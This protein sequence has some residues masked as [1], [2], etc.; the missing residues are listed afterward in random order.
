[1]RTGTSILSAACAGIL[2]LSAAFF[3][4]PAAAEKNLLVTEGADYF[5]ADYDVVKDVGLAACKSACL[6]DDRCKAFT[7]NTSAGWC[8]LKEGVGE[9]RAVGSA[10]SGRVVES[11]VNARSLAEMRTAELSFLPAGFLDEARRLVGSLKEGPSGFSLDQT[12]AEAENAAAGGNYLLATERMKAGLRIAPDRPD[13][14]LRLAAFAA[15]ANSDDWQ[16]RQR[17]EEERTAAA[18]NAY[19]NADAPR[20][21]AAALALLARSLGARDQWKPAIKAYRGSLALEELPDVRAAYEQALAQHG[22]RIVDHQVDSDAANPRICLNFSDALPAIR[23]DLADFIFVEN[24]DNLSVEASGSQICISGVAHG[25]RYHIRAR[26]G[27]PSADGEELQKTAE[28]GIYVRDRSPSARFSGNAYVV[29]AGGSA[30]LPVTTVNTDQIEAELY[31]IPDRGIAGTMR[32]DLFLSQ[33]RDWQAEE[34][35]NAKGEKIWKGAV[36]VENTLN[37]EVVT[38]IPIGE[39]VSTLQPGIYVLRASAR[40]EQESWTPEAT[41]WFLASDLGIATLSGN[42]GLHAS[43]RALGTAAPVEGAKLRLVAKNNEVLAEAAT[44]ASGQASFAP[45]LVRG[46]GG[47]APAILVAE[48]DAGD[49]NFLDL[50]KPAFDLTDRGVEG[51]AA[52]GPVDVFATTERGIYRAGETVYLTTLARNGRSEAIANLPLTAKLFRPDGKEDRSILLEDEGLGGALAEIDLSANAMRGQ[53]RA[54]IYTDPKG[55]SV[56]ETSFF[57]EDFEPERLDFEL[58][59]AAQA[60]DPASPPEITAEARFLYGAPASGLDAE[61]EAIVSASD[62]IEAFPGYRFGLADEEFQTLREPQ[63]GLVTDGEGR[64]DF[65]PTLPDGMV[66]SRP[67][68]AAI[69]IRVVD[70][71]GR[72]VERSLKLPVEGNAPRIGIRPAFQGEVDDNSDAA[73][74]VIAISPEGERIAAEDL[75]WTLSKVDRDYQW[76]RSNGEWNYEVLETRRHVSDGTARVGVEAPAAI[77]APVEWGKYEIE[78][79]SKSGDLLPASFTFEAGWYAAPKTLETPEFL[80]LSLDKERYRIGETAV[81]HLE[82]RFAGIAQVMVIDDRLI[83]TK[84]VEVSEGSAEIELPVTEDWGPGAYVTAALYRPMD[85]A[86]KRMPARAL[87]LSWASVENEAQRLNVSLEA[88]SE[89]KPR[90][91][92][93][94]SISI[95][96]L[97]EGDE[98]YVTLAAVDLGILNLTGFET[99]DPEAFYLGQRRLGMEI[100]DVYSALIDRFAGAPGRVR[101]GGDAALARFEGPAPTEEL[102]AWHSSVVR[103]GPDG[104]ASFDVPVGDFNG[105]VRLMALAWSEKGVGHGEKDVL[106]R[107]PV[108]VSAALPRFMAPGDTSRIALDI[109]HAEGPAGEVSVTVTSSDENV[110]RPASAPLTT[111]LAEGGRE[112]L[113]VP[114]D[115]I[116]EGDATLS[117]AL[118]TPAGEVLEKSL[119]LTVRDGEPEILRTS[120][121]SLAPGSS[122]DLDGSILDGLKPGSAG[123]RVSAYGAGRLDVPAILRKLDRYPYGCAEQLTSRALPLVY[124]NEVSDALGMARDKAA[125][126]RIEKAIEGVLAYQSSSGSFGLWR[127]GSDDL[128]LDSYVTD[129]LSRARRAGYT[130]PE[131]AFSIALDNLKNRIAYAPDFSDAGEDIAYALYVLAENGRAAIGDLRYYAETKL[132]DFVTPLAKAQIGAALALYGDRSLSSS[133]FSRAVSDLRGVNDEGFRFD[134]GSRLRDGAAILTL[135][136][137]SD[138]DSVDLPLLASFV[139]DERQAQ[140][141]TSTQEDAWSLLAANALMKGAVRPELSVGGER[142]DGPMSKK[143]DEAAI[144]AGLSVENRGA[145]PVDVAISATG[146]SLTSEPASGNGYMIERA[147][148]TLQG[149]PVDPANVAQG[150]RLVVVLTVTADAAGSGNLILDDPLPAGFEIDNPNILRG[151]D[152]GALDWLDLSTEPAHTE[153]RADRFI[154]AMERSQSNATRFSLAYVVRAVSPGDFAHPAATIEDMYRPELRART[155]SGRVHVEGPLR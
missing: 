63:G 74:S 112:Q 59:T 102:V 133:I 86:E 56:A 101:T 54:A 19:L 118:T 71:S 68:E 132:D 82:P 47:M 38:A 35:E 126:E 42:D 7:Y 100:R 95:A 122:V 37:R 151:G 121:I 153:F 99:P 116:A 70:T 144:R 152:V 83:A 76:Y 26:A 117:V 104:K 28:L 124:L 143:V 148:Y 98:A 125:D 16:V 17:L 32:D 23:T 5:G 81:V 138:I 103:L 51:R 75:T 91:T 137:E 106:V 31:F 41:Q 65:R 43:L 114:L 145:A 24:G 8:F 29:P 139:A 30:T 34:I 55:A 94:A 52:P 120:F 40:N 73:F 60:I 154:A 140:S 127:P 36:E 147:T 10:I 97:A 84:S 80:K 64:L 61:G 44:D 25:R 18:V 6:A 77:S 3:S 14:W 45:G 155:N 88:P 69:N 46:T 123:L 20:E 15:Q 136:S 62:T 58:Q 27:L 146:R 4:P 11:A 66:S 119:A 141:R 67:L 128:W 149:E 2:A 21:R 78:V 57:V 13:L 92:F 93:A 79:A 22:F 33:L 53:W 85:I 12:L 115:A 9:L 113:L 72:P 142:F 110:V 135:A 105:T 96:G 87:G 89:A 48:T 131:T 108:V 39:L 150:D 134:Y 111:E 49:Y 50:S 1:M 107:D 90:G 130:V 109:A 129:F